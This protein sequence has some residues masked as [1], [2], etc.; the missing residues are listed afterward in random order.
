M[1]TRKYIWKSTYNTISSGSISGHLIR[2]FFKS[3]N[4]S[5]HTYILGFIFGMGFDNANRISILATSTGSASS[6][7]SLVTILALPILFTADMSLIDTT[8][9]FLWQ[10]LTNEF[11]KLHCAKCIIT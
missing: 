2:V 3:I 11:Y 9:V 5:W 6:S 1:L 7:I 8:D 10:Q 4:K